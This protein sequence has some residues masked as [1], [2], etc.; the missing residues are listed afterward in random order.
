M[1]AVAS[2]L[3]LI[4]VTACSGPTQQVDV[5]APGLTLDL[6]QTAALGVATEQCSG[7]VTYLPDTRIVSVEEQSGA[8]EFVFKL[9]ENPVRVPGEYLAAGNT[10]YVTVRNGHAFVAKH[11]CASVCKEHR[12]T[13][14]PPT[15]SLEYPLD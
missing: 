8:D 14:D 3:A 11:A 6:K 13:D 1:R 10:C 5:L 12:V 15:G 4:A 9:P 2:T 7:I